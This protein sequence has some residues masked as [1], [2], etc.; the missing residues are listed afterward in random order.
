MSGPRRRDDV[1]A[2][3]I[4]RLRVATNLDNERILALMAD[5][6]MEGGLVLATRRDPDFFGLYRLQRGDNELWV[7]DDDDG[8]ALKG[9]GGFLVR[10]GFLDGAPARVG[11]LGDLRTRGLARE[12]LAFPQVYA[13]LFSR[14]VEQ[15]GCEHFLT[16]VMADN[17]RAI[18]ALSSS[19]SKSRRRTAQPYYHLLQRFEM[20]NLHLVGRLPRR[21]ASGIVVRT[22]TTTDLGA[23]TALLAADHRGRPFGFRFDDGEFEHRLLHWPG[24]SLEHTFCAFSDDGRLL[25]VTTCFD[26]SPVKRYRVLRYA[27]QMVAVKRALDV[28]ARLTGCAPLPEPG[29]DFRSLYLTNLSIVDDNPAVL[30]ALIDFIYPR[31]VRAGFHFVSFPLFEGDPLTSGAKGYVVRRIPFHLYAVTSSSRA[32]TQWQRGRPGFEMAL[33]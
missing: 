15:T 16:A 12:R 26:P 28:A 21:R 10:D 17:E 3:T 23:I 18:R 4:A 33:A 13:H 24:F 6:P 1:V 7:F 31:V 27:G 5:V 11:Y 14:T 2:A 29:D 30:Q 20:A 9:M 19:S 32:R 25:G 8:C 22:A